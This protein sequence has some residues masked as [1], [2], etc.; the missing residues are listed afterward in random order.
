MANYED[1]G[2]NREADK[3]VATIRRVASVANGDG[4]A[5][6]MMKRVVAA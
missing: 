3:Q 2:V 5:A 6:M 4:E 1:T